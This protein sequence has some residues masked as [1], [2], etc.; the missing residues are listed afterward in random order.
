[1]LQNELSF[2]E[3][4]GLCLS[5]EVDLVM[6]APP[7]P[8]PLC[9]RGQFSDYGDFFSILAHDIEYL[10]LAG[11]LT[12]G[13]LVLS[14]VSTVSTITPKWQQLVSIYSGPA[15]AI[16]SADAEDWASADPRALYLV[17]ANRIEFQAGP[18]WD[19]AHGQ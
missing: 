13:D 8:F 3:V 17:I 19:R 15:L 9:L 16:R 6:C 18:D 7:A 4:R 14:D 2:D 12:V 1:M 10:D 5:R 11:G